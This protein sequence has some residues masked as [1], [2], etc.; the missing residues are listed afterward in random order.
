MKKELIEMF[1][2]ILANDFSNKC[3]CKDIKDEY[4]EIEESDTHFKIKLIKNPE[5][6]I[7]KKALEIMIKNKKTK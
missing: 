5:F 6:K 4:F 2:E 3:E 7:N 1:S